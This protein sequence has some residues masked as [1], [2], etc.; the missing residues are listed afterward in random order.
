MF[1]IVNLTNN[2]RSPAAAFAAVDL[3]IEKERGD[4]AG[5]VV[6]D[7][8]GEGKKEEAESSTISFELFLRASFFLL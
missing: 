5:H 6:V 7:L 8:D 2:V 3:S 1:V 4:I